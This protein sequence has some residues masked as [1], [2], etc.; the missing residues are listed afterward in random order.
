MS[1]AFFFGYGSLVNRGTHHFTPLH[2]ATAHG[3]RR[4][5]RCTDAREA[6]FLTAV[7]DPDGTLLGMIA[8]VPADDWAA[9]DER[10]AAYDRLGAGL[11]ITHEAPGVAELALYAIAP[12]RMRGPSDA[13]PLLLSYLDVVVQGYLLEYGVE[14]AEHFF[15][16]T[17]GWDCPILDDRAAPRYPRAQR[18]GDPERAVVDR[19]LARLGSRRIAA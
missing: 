18:L 17:D 15:A 19:H 14:G 2:P 11:K 16:T 12:E 3:W 1:G 8:H 6:A 5:W 7:P 13:H 9:L 4:A 10:E